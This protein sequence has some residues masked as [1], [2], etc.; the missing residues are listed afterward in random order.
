MLKSLWEVHKKIYYSEN[1]LHASLG[2]GIMLSTGNTKE[3]G[4]RKY[5]MS[6]A[7]AYIKASYCRTV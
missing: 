5:P 1:V 3:T 6:V 2:P 7:E 4:A